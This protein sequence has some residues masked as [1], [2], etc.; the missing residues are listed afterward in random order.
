MELIDAG[1]V[2]E[3]IPFWDLREFLLLRD[4]AA[5]FLGAAGVFFGG[6]LFGC[7]GSI[8]KRRTDCTS[9]TRGRGDGIPTSPTVQSVGVY[10]SSLKMRDPT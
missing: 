5:A 2:T 10:E 8:L 6:M 3:V 7:M 4:F 1:A 9:V